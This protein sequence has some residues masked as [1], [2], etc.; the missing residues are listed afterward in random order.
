MIGKITT[1]DHANQLIHSYPDSLNN[2]TIFITTVIMPNCI[3]YIAELIPPNHFELIFGFHWR[4][5]M[6]NSYMNSGKQKYILLSSIGAAWT[7]TN[8]ISAIS[9]PPHIEL[10]G[11]K[12]VSP[13]STSVLQCTSKEAQRRVHCVWSRKLLHMPG[14]RQ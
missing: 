2:S 12:M 3:K 10:T 11:E 1:I 7:P 5:R 4:H 6:I 8:V 14:I 13:C 9:T